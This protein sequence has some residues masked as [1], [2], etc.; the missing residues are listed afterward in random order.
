MPIWPAHVGLVDERQRD[1]QG[2]LGGWQFELGLEHADVAGL[3][4]RGVVEGN[5]AEAERFLVQVDV[6]RG[7][8]ERGRAEVGEV[9]QAERPR[10]SKLEVAKSA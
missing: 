8:A 5:Q 1:A 2:I 4:D 10:D 6:E 9:A 3:V 7:E